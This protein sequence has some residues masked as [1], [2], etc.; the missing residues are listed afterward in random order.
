[1]VLAV[2]VSADFVES[3]GDGEFVCHPRCLTPSMNLVSVL[4]LCRRVAVVMS[5]VA[6]AMSAVAVMAV[7]IMR[8]L[9]C[10]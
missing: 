10:R 5:A 8:V 1:M 4:C 7:R 6:V 9:P 2:S 3:G